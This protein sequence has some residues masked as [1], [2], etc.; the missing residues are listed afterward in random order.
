[1]CCTAGNFQPG[2]GFLQRHDRKRWHSAAM[3][4]LPYICRLYET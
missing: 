2:D 1:M 4:E 3:Q